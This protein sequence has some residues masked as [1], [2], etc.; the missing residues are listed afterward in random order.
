MTKKSQGDPAAARAY[1]SGASSYDHNVKGFDV[2]ARLGFDL[3]GWRRQAVAELNLKP[4][5]TVVDIGC[6]TG[7][8]FTV[9][10]ETITAEGSIIGVDLSAAMLE[11]ARERVEVNGWKNVE[12]ICADAAQFEL[13]R[14]VDGV[15][16]AYALILIADSPRVVEKA[17]A[18]LKP[19]GRL[20]IL[21]MSWPQFCPL[22]WRHVLFFLR[23]YGVTADILRARPWL[24]VQQSMMDRLVGFSCRRFWFGFFYLASGT[25][26][27][28][29]N[30]TATSA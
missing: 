10:Q 25:A 15:L 26:H 6:G 28:E 12:L 14:P 19:G 22:W 11:G 8:N 30:G 23:S 9:L 2:F 29:P 5:D 24:A 7:L 18:A 27:S 13:E 1:G 3:S 4:G 16:S 21:D 17:C 20:S